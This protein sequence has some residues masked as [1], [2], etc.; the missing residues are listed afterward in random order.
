M[1][2]HNQRP[3]ILLYT[4]LAGHGHLDGW[5]AIFA[6]AL[7]EQGHA[8]TCLTPDAAALAS[9]LEA[10]GLAG[11]RNPALVPWPAPH[12]FSAVLLGK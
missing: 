10:K 5:L 4:P 8:V 3:S 11:R 12:Q 1:S 2:A 9:R 7:A 6:A